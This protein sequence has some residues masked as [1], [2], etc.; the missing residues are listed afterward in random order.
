MTTPTAL[1]LTSGATATPVNKNSPVI[2]LEHLGDADDHERGPA[3]HPAQL[4]S[5]AAAGDVVTFAPAGVVFRWRRRKLLADAARSKGN[6][7]VLEVNWATSTTTG[8]SSSNATWAVIAGPA[9][10]GARTIHRHPRRGHQHGHRDRDAGH[11]RQP[12]LRVAGV[13]HHG[14]RRPSVLLDATGT[15][16]ACSAT[17]YPSITPGHG[18]G[19]PC[20]SGTPSTPA[21]PAAAARAATPTNPNVDGINEPGSASTRRAPR[22]RRRPAWADSNTKSWHSG[23]AVR[24]GPV[25]RRAPWSP[26]R[27]SLP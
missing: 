25:A 20:T 4:Q 7:I 27:R 6:I 13:Q 5:A 3:R 26:C 24:G 1:T 11:Q 2:T 21:R 8:A 22:R 18:A 10:T 14:G 23:A 16:N 15:V 19:E 12:G 9:V 17:A